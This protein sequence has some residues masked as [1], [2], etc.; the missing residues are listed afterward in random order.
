[1]IKASFEVL[2]TGNRQSFLV[3]R[4]DQWAFDGPYHFHPE[5]ELTYITKGAGKRYVGS[6]MEDFSAGDLVLLGPNLPH[7]WKLGQQSMKE[8]NA[9]AIVAAVTDASTSPSSYALT[10]ICIRSYIP[11]VIKENAPI[12][13]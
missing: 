10:N 1:M 8:G 2:Q 12:K 3:R 5:Y 13:V 4:F 9:G 7:C 11:F 6:H